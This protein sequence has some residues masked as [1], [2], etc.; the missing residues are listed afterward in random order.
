MFK[1]LL[2]SNVHVRLHEYPKKNKINQFRVPSPGEKITV[3]NSVSFTVHY[4][5]CSL[6]SGDLGGLFQSR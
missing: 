2:S 3:L 1:G 5:T 6:S 4:W